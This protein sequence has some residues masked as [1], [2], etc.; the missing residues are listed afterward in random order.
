MQKVMNFRDLGG[1]KTTDG[2]TIKKGLFFRS[3]MLNDATE[4]DIE[5]LKSLKLKHV[6]DYRDDDELALMKNN[7]YELIGVSHAHY[8]V[9]LNNKKLLQLK[10]SSYLSRIFQRVTLDDVKDTYR[11]L[12]FNNIGYKAMVKALKKGEVPIYQHC[13]AGKDRA[14]LGSALLLAILGADYNEILQDYLK[15]IEI[16]E[17][18]ENK[19]GGFIPK[20]MRKRL[21]RR[22]E[23]LFIVD[24]TLLDTSIQAILEKYATI[25][26]YLLQEYQLTQQDISEIREKY[27][28]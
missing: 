23:A 17:Y 7:P 14:G 11:H 19:I 8:P 2:K 18:I 20:I 4:Q 15:S 12:P 13:T 3:A 1:L 10:K 24:K 5:F 26:K 16:K 25:E 28:E 22:F 27:T 6:F 21:L 9:Y